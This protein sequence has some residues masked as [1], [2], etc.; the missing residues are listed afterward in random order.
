M[1][2]DESR[3][4]GESHRSYTDIDPSHAKRIFSNYLYSYGKRNTLV[5]HVREYR[6]SH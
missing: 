6:E 4:S 5:G 1:G 3:S 2:Q